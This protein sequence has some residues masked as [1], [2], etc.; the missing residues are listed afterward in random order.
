M[1]QEENA[2]PTEALDC[3]MGDSF[4]DITDERTKEFTAMYE[5]MGLSSEDEDVSDDPTHRP[6]SE[7]DM[8]QED[9]DIMPDYEI[10]DRLGRGGCA[11]VYE[12]WRKSDRFHVAIKQLAIPATADE[13]EEHIARRRFYRE[14]KL[15]TPL[16]EQHIVQCVDYGV[17]SEGQPCMVHQG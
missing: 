3:E 2:M 15:I 4:N 10:G 14:A 16:K 11:I 9:H 1:S 13:E 8:K 12:G 17:M 5:Q 6:L 7:E